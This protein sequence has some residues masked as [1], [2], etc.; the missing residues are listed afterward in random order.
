MVALV[1]RDTEAME[2][3]Y[4]GIVRLYDLI[5]DLVD[6]AEVDA[7]ENEGDKLDLVEPVILKVEELTKVLVSEYRIF[8]KTNKIPDRFTKK[9]INSLITGVK[10]EIGNCR[11]KLPS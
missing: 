5:N 6:F 8:A 11:K 7:V 9:R 10:V 3:V 1:E 4:D 2:E